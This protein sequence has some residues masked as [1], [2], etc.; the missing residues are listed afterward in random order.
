MENLSAAP[1]T[2][3]GSYSTNGGNHYDSEGLGKFPESG[4]EEAG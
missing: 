3:N 2:T 4:H 1:D